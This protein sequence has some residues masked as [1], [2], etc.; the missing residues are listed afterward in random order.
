MYGEIPHVERVAEVM[1]SKFPVWLYHIKN[2]FD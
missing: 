1:T 2:E